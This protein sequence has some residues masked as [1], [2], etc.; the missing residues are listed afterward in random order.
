MLGEHA[1]EILTERYFAVEQDILIQGME[2]QQEMEIG[3]IPAWAEISV[4]TSP[5]KANIL[6][7][8]QLTGTTPDTIEILEG[9]Y[10]MLLTKKGFKP[11]E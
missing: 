10:V 8:G 7:D 4:A 11:F 3:L 6:I 1:L 2:I 9:E 5:I